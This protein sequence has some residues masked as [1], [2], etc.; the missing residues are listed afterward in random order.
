[1]TLHRGDKVK[2]LLYG[3]KIAVR[4]VVRIKGNVVVICAEEEYA[5]AMAEGRDPDGVGFP[6]QDIVSDRE[7]VAQ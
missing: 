7:L 5:A 4:R 3:G 2:A 6:R 1:M